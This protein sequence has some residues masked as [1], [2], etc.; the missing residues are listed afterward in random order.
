MTFTDSSIDINDHPIIDPGY[1]SHPADVA[2]L[3]G[4]LTLIEKIFKH[5]ALAP[6]IESRYLPEDTSVDL[7]DIEQAKQSVR[8]WCLSEYHVTGS[9]AMGAALDS[10]LKVNG[11][12]NIRVADASVFPNNVS[13]NIC[14]SVYTVAEKAADIIKADHSIQ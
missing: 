11:A 4:S 3:G 8:D 6:M 7:S 10:R 1:L 13:G 9:V 5:E 12:S 2:V 14:S